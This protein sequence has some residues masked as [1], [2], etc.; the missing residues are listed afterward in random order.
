MYQ[1]YCILVKFLRRLFNAS[2]LSLIAA[3]CVICATAAND[4]PD[5]GASSDNALNQQQEQQLGQQIMQQIRRF[6][7]LMTDPLLIDYINDLG[8]HL[9]SH[10]PDRLEQ[11]FEF[12]IVSEPHINA[13]ALP[14]GYIG[15]HSGLIL[16]A[17]RESEL[18]AVMGHEIAHVSQRHL[19]RRI[20]RQQSLQ[21]P[22]LLAMIGSILIAATSPQ[23]G[24]AAISATQAA[25]IQSILSHTREN[26]READRIGIQILANSQ[27]EPKAMAGFFETLAAQYQYSQQIPEFL[28]SHPVTSKRI[29]EARHLERQLPP[30]VVREQKA[31]DLFQER[32]YFLLNQ[33]GKPAQKPETTTKAAANYRQQLNAIRQNNTKVAL[34]NCGEYTHDPLEIWFEISC[35]EFDHQRQHYQAALQRL[36]EL[37][38]RYPGRLSIQW[39]QA[40][41]LFELERYSQATVLLKQVL[42]NRPSFMPAYALLSKAYTGNNQP[43]ESLETDAQ[44]H[45]QL[46]NFDR[47]ET[48]LLLAMKETSSDPLAHHRVKA[49]LKKVRDRL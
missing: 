24:M 44:Y 20:Q 18:A 15:L 38:E 8:Y 45:M 27:F 9:V 17:T 31:F 3:S 16:S 23:A 28:S 26:E 2:W 10:H 22:T 19:S 41:S 5:I 21:V 43:L 49:R 6:D 25:S 30:I 42:L 46:G 11:P 34:A 4:L 13:F 39:Q 1:T 40:L 32:L 7:D 48:S 14:G 37:A 12:F 29:A 47:A 36:T 33:L 35:A